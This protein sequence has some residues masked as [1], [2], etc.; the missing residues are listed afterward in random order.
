M[1]HWNETSNPQQRQELAVPVAKGKGMGVML[2]KVVRPRET[3][4]GLLPKD[5]VR[6]ALSLQGPNGLVLGMDSMD[7]VKSN[8]EILRTFIP[9][10]ENE[11]K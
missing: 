2:M 5:L 6:Y 3:V 7:I 1:N 4:P 9:M 8:L 10:N 11:M